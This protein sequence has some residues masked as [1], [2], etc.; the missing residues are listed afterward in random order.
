M[1]DL[2]RLLDEHEVVLTEGAVIERLKRNLAVQLDAY[3]ANATLACTDVGRLEMGR[4]YREYLDVG[5][6]ANLPMAV[7]TP[8]WRASA[9]RA[10]RAGVGLDVNR[11][12]YEM[13]DGIRSDYGNYGAQVAVGGLIGPRADA[14]RPATALPPDAALEYHRPQVEALAFAGVDFVMGATLP[15]LSEGLGIARAAAETGVACLI[16][17]VLRPD[18]AVLDG[19]VLAAAIRRIDAE[20][21]PWPL[22][23][24][25]NCVHPETFRNAAAQLRAVEEARLQMLGLQA[26]ASRK[27]LAALD[28]A[29]ETDAGDP[30]EFGRQMAEFRK[31]FGLRMLGGCCGT[32]ARH[33]RAI[34]RALG[35]CPDR[36]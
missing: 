1:A 36:P 11:V 24:L 23:Y 8:T 19:T 20:V 35:Y 31:E 5:R 34:A 13:L 9:E 32:D 6:A 18:G 10:E 29:E 15:A 3:V 4:I 33:I 16:S 27:P 17:F 7:F 22:G 14:Y 21:S 26:N 30:V 12:A 2:R 28:C 25:V